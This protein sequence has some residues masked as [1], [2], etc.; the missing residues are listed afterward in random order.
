MRP[1]GLGDEMT[2]ALH[3]MTSRVVNGKR[4]PDLMFFDLC[5]AFAAPSFQGVAMGKIL[6][7]TVLAYSGRIRTFYDFGK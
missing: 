2:R 6:E 7:C 5:R 1:A 4:L 3:L